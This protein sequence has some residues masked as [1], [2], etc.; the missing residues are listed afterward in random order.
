MFPGV[1]SQCLWHS[2][3]ERIKGLL[4]CLSINTSVVADRRLEGELLN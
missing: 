1:M 2:E 4:L 3:P